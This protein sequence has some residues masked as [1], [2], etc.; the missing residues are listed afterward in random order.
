MT[1]LYAICILHPDG[2][3]NVSGIVHF[4]QTAP[5]EPTEIVA[6]VKGLT[7]NGTHGFHIHQYGDLTCGCVTA[8]PHFNPHGKTHGGPNDEERHV[9]D[10]GNLTTDAD[11]NALFKLT[12][13]MISLHGEF[14]ILGRSCVVHAGVDDLG[15]GGHELSPTT[16]N[17][18]ARRACGT[19]GLSAKFTDL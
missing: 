12:D 14:S 15:K 8:G 4:K 10:L 7:A 16:G 18:G 11:G 5:G 3:S 2:G 17:A 19:I 6:H 9:G 13:H 1:T